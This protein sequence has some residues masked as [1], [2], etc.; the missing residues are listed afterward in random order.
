MSFLLGAK[1]QATQPAAISGL[2]L[3]SSSYGKAVSIIYG[4]TRI[5]PNLIWYGDFVAT[6]QSSSSSA[7]GGKGGVTGGGGGGKGGGGSTSY[8]Y[9]TAVALGLCEGPI[10][11]VGDVYV[12]QSITS[13]AALGLSLFTGTYPQ[14]AWGYLAG[15]HSDQSIGYN[16][17][18]YL[19]TAAYQLGTSAQLPNNNFEVYGIYSDSLSSLD[20]PDADPSLVVYDLL[21]NAYYGCGFPSGRIGDFSVYQSYCI[22]S[23]LWISPAYTSQTQASSLL[24]DISSAT[25]SAFVWS[26]GLLTLVPYGDAA[27]TENGY[28]YTPPASPLYT[29]TD[30]DFLPNSNAT[31]GSSGAA[32]DDPIILTRTRQSDAYNSVKL[33]CLDRNNSYNPAI[34][35]AKDQALIEMYGL[36]Q[37]SAAQMHLFAD[38]NAGQISAQLQLQRQSVRNSYQFTLDQRYVLLDPMDIVSITDSYLGLNQQW[39]RITEITENDDGSLSIVAEE[40]LAGSGNAPLYSYQQGQGFNANY[41]VSPG[42]ANQPVIFEPT[43]LLAGDLEVWLAVSGGPLW[44]GCNVYISNDGSSYKNA[45][46]IHGSSRTG[47]L[48]SALSA[49][50]EAATGQTIDTADTLSVDLSQSNGELLSGSQADATSLATLCYVDGEYVAYQNATLTG[51]N[52]YNLTYLVRAA[53]GT[54]ASAHSAGADFARLDNSIFKYAYT[55][56]FIG[57]TLYIKFASFNIYGGGQQTL[58]D[59]QPYTYTLTGLALSTPLPDIAN[60]RTSYIASLTQLTWDE[61]QDFRSVL[62][63]VRKGAAW[64]GAQVLGRVAHP[65]FCAQGTGTYW[66]A[67]YSQPVAGLQVYSE[68]PQDLVISGAQIT[69]NVIASYDEAATGWTGSTGGT[70]VVV[71][72]SVVTSGAGNILTDADF[73]NTPDILFYGQEGNGVYEI[74]ASHRINIGR[75]APC[76]VIITWMSGGQHVHDNILTVSN[77]LNFSDVLDYQAAANV[78][79]YPEIALSQDGVSWG[80]WQKYTAGTYLAWAYKARMQMEIYDP[81]VEALLSE[82]IFAVDVPDRDDHYVNLSI[83]SGGMNLIFKPDGS[84]TATP[85]NGGPQ[86]ATGPAIQVTILSAQ[87]GDVASI[88]AVTFSG[89]TVQILNGGSGVARNVNLLAEGY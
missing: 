74:P 53:Y 29:L 13:I 14:S 80:A 33:E 87:P 60:L 39:V 70:A 15:A 36:R 56:D 76:G 20:I 58:A 8:T 43:A 54:H 27:I 10:Q 78:N 5:A 6:A 61:I 1:S 65:P 38:L 19:A 42:N 16:G 77:F 55:Q 51:G 25:N 7:G 82:F 75:L 66:V 9:Q 59:V 48:T 83:P 89:C 46:T 71:S 18:G 30:D 28:S 85:F 23:G 57:T 31:A 11:N 32:N 4:T 21:T 69:S 63:E 72:G 44:G 88:T 68:T 81:S 22:A 62:Y 86:G 17:I 26:S 49:V 45:G 67:A 34:V 24:D 12:D 41:N 73:L 2:Q 52:T 37:A 3:Q 84:S 47:K 79:V 64:T 40:Y 35:E 50:Q